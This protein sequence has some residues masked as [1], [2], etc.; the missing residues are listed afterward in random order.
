MEKESD[1]AKR[2]AA[3][4]FFVQFCFAYLSLQRAI[5]VLLE[6]KK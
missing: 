6:V 5:L 2:I 3:A 4:L 1:A